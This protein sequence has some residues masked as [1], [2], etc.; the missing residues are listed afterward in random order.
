MDP[1]QRLID[2]ITQMCNIDGLVDDDIV[3]YFETDIQ[4]YINDHALKKTRSKNVEIINQWL[5]KNVEV[6]KYIR[7]LLQCHFDS[8]S[9]T[10][11]DEKTLDELYESGNLEKSALEHCFCNIFDDWTKTLPITEDFQ[12]FLQHY[13]FSIDA[14]EEVFIFTAFKSLDTAVQTMSDWYKENEI[15]LMREYITPSTYCELEDQ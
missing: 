3:E 12:K 10:S 1:K 6:N 15:T 2:A 14:P 5:D 13:P 7:K 4:H 9:M 11:I 8:L